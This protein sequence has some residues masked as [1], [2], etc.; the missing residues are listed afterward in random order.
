MREYRQ[1]MEQQRAKEL[2][3]TITGLVVV[4][5]CVIIALIARAI[6]PSDAPELTITPTITAAP[7]TLTAVLAPISTNTPAP[8]PTAT[9]VPT[10]TP[11]PTPIIQVSPA[12]AQGD[13][14]SYNDLVPVQSVPA[15]VDIRAAS[16]APDL[17]ITLQGAGNVP[18]ELSGWAE[19]EVLLWVA[20]YEPVPDPPSAY[21]EWLFVLDLDGNTE[22]GRPPG[23]LHTNP[24]L[25]V[26]VA[27][28]AYYDPNVGAY[29]T[30]SLVWDP[31]VGNWAD[32]PAGVHFTLSESRAVVG[33]ALPMD[34]LTQSAAQVAG[35]TVAPG[36]VRGR[37]ATLATVDQRIIDFYPD[38]P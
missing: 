19:G 16:A 28:A 37:A 3:L 31:T 2:R 8:I 25:G 10:E 26:E 35:V 20:L 9:P 13:V 4:F 27:I 30:Y 7:A 38:R 15:G 33:I 21:T 14:V 24:D 22:T 23:S 1:L 18:S 29:E 12:D 32:G 6:L 11:L 17:R 34:A 5:L 36:A